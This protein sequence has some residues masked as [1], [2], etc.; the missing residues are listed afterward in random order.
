MATRAELQSYRNVLAASRG[1][2]A[3]WVKQGKNLDQVL[4]AKPTAKWEEQW[5]KGFM[6]ADTFVK[7]VYIN[8]SGKKV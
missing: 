8:L 5:G 7:V 4:A 1:E 2:V 6:K 3:M